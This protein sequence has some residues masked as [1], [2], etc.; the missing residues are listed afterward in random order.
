MPSYLS[1][2]YGAYARWLLDTP[3]LSNGLNLH[4]GTED[5]AWKDLAADFTAVTGIKVVYKDVTLDEYFNLEIFPAP[6]TVMGHSAHPDDPTL[7]T[8]RENF[9]GF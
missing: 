3:T 4:V 7:F 2:G 9:S 8:V 6:D 1:W 5:I